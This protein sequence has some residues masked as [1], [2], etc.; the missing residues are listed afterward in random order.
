MKATTHDDEHG[1]T[2]ICTSPSVP[3][4][5]VFLCYCRPL[6]LTQDV[7]LPTS[8]LYLWAFTGPFLG[9]VGEGLLD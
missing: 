3:P 5:T 8:L 1:Q 6:G 7:P 4:K 9:D 2:G